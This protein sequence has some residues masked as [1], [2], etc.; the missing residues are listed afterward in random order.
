MEG[1]NNPRMVASEEREK[2]KTQMQK[3][4]KNKKPQTNKKTQT[5]Q[6]SRVIGKMED[7]KDP[8]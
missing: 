4:N 5:L 3:K 2:N 8:A 6:D 7:R 1:N